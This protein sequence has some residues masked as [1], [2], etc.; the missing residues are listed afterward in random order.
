MTFELAG[1]APCPGGCTAR[2][3]RAGRAQ[4]AT[5]PIAAAAGI[6]EATA[7]F[8]GDAAWQPATDVVP[9]LVVAATPPPLPAGG[10]RLTGGGWVGG[11][12]ARP[13][14]RIHFAVEATSAIPVPSGDLRWLDR[15]AGVDLSGVRYRTWT[16]SGG[17]V[18][19]TGTGR[20]ADGQT[21]SFI[22]RARDVA[23]PGRDADTIT[24]EIPELGY[25]AGGV[26]G[27][28]NLQLHQG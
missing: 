14:E 9:V 23:E 19:L 4:V 11:A 3:D 28:G 26:L 15:A 18:T 13:T 24:L 1:G 5:E 2:T 21:V 25:E 6:T 27:G 16:L 22:L 7:T 20:L 12:S 10:G 17:E 8:T